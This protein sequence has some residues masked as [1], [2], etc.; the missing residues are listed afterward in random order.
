MNDEFAIR[1][2]RQSY[3]HGVDSKNWNLFGSVLDEDSV[4]DLRDATDPPMPPITGRRAIVLAISETLAAYTTVH[5]G[6][7]RELTF[8]GTDQASAVWSME[9][10]L[11]TGERGNLV[12]FLHGYGHYHDQYKKVDG[13]WRIASCRLTRI[14]VE[15]FQTI[16]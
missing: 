3:F 15:L 16:S 10:I 11:W 4:L 8:A 2:V 13:T 5:H 14:S 7:L 6:F 9:D 12:K 1:T